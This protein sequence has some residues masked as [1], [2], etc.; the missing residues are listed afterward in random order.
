MKRYFSDPEL[1]TSRIGGADLFALMADALKQGVV[2]IDDRGRIVLANAVACGFF[3]QDSAA[4]KGQ[5]IDQW[6]PSYRFSRPVGAQSRRDEQLNPSLQL[7]RNADGVSSRVAVTRRPFVASGNAGELVLIDEQD[8]LIDLKKQVRRQQALMNHLSTPC[9]IQS[10]DGRIETANPAFERTFGYRE[11]EVV[12]RLPRE[13]LAGPLTH[14]E[15]VAAG[16]KAVMSGGSVKRDEAMYHKDGSLI[17]VNYEQH[18]VIDELGD[19]GFIVTTAT[20]ISDRVYA[21]Q[22]KTDFVSMVGHELRTPL[23]VVSGSIDVL[24][25]RRF[26]D[27][28]EPIRE[29]VGGARRGCDSLN[30]LIGDL[31]DINKIEAGLVDMHTDT[32]SVAEVIERALDELADKARKR[33]VTMHMPPGG[34]CAVLA[35]KDRL[36]Q[37]VSNL[38]SN[39]IKYGKAGG[40]VYLSVVSH[41]GRGQVTLD[42]IDDG[43]GIDAEL[44][45][46]L[47]EKFSRSARAAAQG[48]EGFGLGL[49]ICK[50]LA[51]QMGGSLKLVKNR[52]GTGAQFRLTLPASQPVSPTADGCE[53]VTDRTVKPL[54]ERSIQARA[55]AERQAVT[56]L[57]GF[58]K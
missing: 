14:L 12:G 9:I 48:I 22:M 17:W 37:I 2:V 55:R 10:S 15:E 7:M 44:E 28:P 32:V 26:V 35:D 40:N 39:A 47:F 54:A 45:P 4:L 19:I 11:D 18:G 23:T 41:P 50:G 16:F 43:P 51:E 49:S 57:D 13:L 52:A 33:Q 53:K 20:D 25:D 31:L 5:Q 34:D 21:E 30:L 29:I 56:A 27:L 24:L 38:V 3:G 6:L 36:R 42:V 8:E 46:R 1:P 58:D